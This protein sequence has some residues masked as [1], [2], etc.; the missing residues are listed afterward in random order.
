MT[1][2]DPSITV[3]PAVI[4]TIIGLVVY[5]DRRLRIVE[6]QLS[7]LIGRMEVEQDRENGEV[8]RSK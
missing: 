5:F 6:T 3:D 1:F 8:K 4:A 2:L 7:R